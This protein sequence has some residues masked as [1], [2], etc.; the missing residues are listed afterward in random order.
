[1]VQMKVKGYFVQGRRS[2]VRL[3]EK[4]GKEHDVPCRHT[5]DEYLD[6]YIAAAGVAADAEGPLFRT[7]AYQ[8]SHLRKSRNIWQ[9]QGWP[10]SFRNSR[11]VL[12]GGKLRIGTPSPLGT[13]PVSSD[14]TRLPCR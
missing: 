10:R 4:N 6:E 13:L 2:W 9:A 3:H 11:C 1:V 14:G 5:L 12:S 8:Y 7:A